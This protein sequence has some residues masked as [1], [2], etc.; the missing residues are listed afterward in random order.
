VERMFES[1]VGGWGGEGGGNEE[2]GDDEG[3]TTITTIE[4]LK[5]YAERFELAAIDLLRGQGA[6]QGSSFSVKLLFAGMRTKQGGP[7]LHT[8]RGE[9]S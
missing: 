7:A 1:V 3:G 2:G 4:K 8:L 9:V 5:S 6:G